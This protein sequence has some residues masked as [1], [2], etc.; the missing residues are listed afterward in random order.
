MKMENQT[1]GI[2]HLEGENKEFRLNQSRM[3]IGRRPGV[4]IVLDDP[5]VSGRHVLV[6]SILDDSFIENLSK[7]NGTFVNGRRVEK[8]VLQNGDTITVGNSKLVYKAEHDAPG[9][10][11]DDFEKTMI[12]KPGQ[13]ARDVATESQA[14]AM[15]DAEDTAAMQAVE[16]E[17]ES[18]VAVLKVRTGAAKGKEVKVDRAMVTL[19]R[20]GVQVIVVSRRKSG[21]YIS[22]ISGASG[23]GKAPTI[24]GKELKS[25]S[26]PLNGG[27]VIT[28]AGVEIEF[29][30]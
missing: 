16:P 18:K 12:L 11:E 30:L 3:V 25:Q 21:Y 26:I 23:S 8:T 9:V 27:D 6:I 2:L 17:P 19:G 1:M 13:V 4:D 22:Y 20:P 29:V 10:D 5:A 15:Q 28:L 14:K 24:N 7:T